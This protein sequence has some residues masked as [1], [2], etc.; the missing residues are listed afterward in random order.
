MPQNWL[1]INVINI[2]LEKYIDKILTE[3]RRKEWGYLINYLEA[4]KR[5]RRQ[6]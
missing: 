6:Q 5:K 3:K 1:L 2:R 4:K